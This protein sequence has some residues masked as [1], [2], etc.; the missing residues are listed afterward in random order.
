MSGIVWSKFFW[1]DWESDPKLRL[2]SAAAQGLWMRMLCI[3]AQSDKQGYLLIESAPLGPTELA[4]LTGWPLAS[5]EGW[6]AELGKWGVYST[7]RKGRVFCRR[8]V[9]DAKKIKTARENGKKGGNPNLGKDKG[10][11]PS[12]NPQAKG[13]DKPHKPKARSQ[14]PEGLE[15]PT[16]VPGEE[17]GFEEAF[18]A[19]PQSGRDC[20]PEDQGRAEWVK[21]TERVEAG[22]LVAA[23]KRYAASDYVR[24]G[25]MVPKFHLWLRK[26]LW[27]VHLDAPQPVGW[28]GPAEL[29]R[30]VC[31]EA[32]EAFARSYL[33]TSEWTPEGVRP[34]TRYAFDKLKPLR[35]MR[36]VTILEPQG[37]AA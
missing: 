15:P 6:F 11:G 22:A 7:D 2:C 23:V 14:E 1:S 34:R 35:A 5:V 20:S 9:L 13:G 37:A 24:T 12:D 17:G 31:Q 28:T 16:P 19:Y 3:C 33:D 4:Q 10:N 25:R 8:M 32:T 26:G 18:A 29:R 27:K 36:G 21:A 30:A